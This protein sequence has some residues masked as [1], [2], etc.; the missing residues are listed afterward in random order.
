MR[1]LEA[2]EVESV[3]GADLPGECSAGTFLGSAVGGAFVGG[4]GG[5]VGGPLMGLGGAVLGG[6]GGMLGAAVGCAI[7]LN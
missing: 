1:N 6:A 7:A 2:F 4:V 3:G 5:L